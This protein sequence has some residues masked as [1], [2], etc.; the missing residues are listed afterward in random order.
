MRISINLSPFV[1]LQRSGASRTASGGFFAPAEQN[2]LLIA[3]SG[4][5]SS[6]PQLQ[7]RLANVSPQIAE[8]GKDSAAISRRAALYADAQ[9]A[10]ERLRQQTLGSDIGA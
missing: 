2:A 6:R 5:Q 9:Q 3:R 1:Q 10:L 8:S 7:P 4:S